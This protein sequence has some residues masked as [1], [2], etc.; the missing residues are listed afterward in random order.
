M[1]DIKT[2]LE[3]ALSQTVNAWAADDKVHRQIEPQQDKAMTQLQAKAYFTVTNNVCRTTFEYV[4]NN[5]GKTRAEVTNDLAAQGFKYKSV[6]S[7]LGQMLKQDMLRVSSGLLFTKSR[8]YAPLK[9]AKTLRNAAEAPRK[10]V[11]IT[12]KAA[13]IVEPTPPRATPTPQEWTVESVIGSLNVRQA[14]AVYDEL[15]KI[16]GG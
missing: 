5:P 13:P 8:E 2:A 3:K 1:P 7:L 11:T 4:Q 14:M 12:R 15:R 10:V 6:S 9:A 16:F